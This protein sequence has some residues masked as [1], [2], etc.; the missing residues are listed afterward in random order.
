MSGVELILDAVA[1]GATAGVT[2]ATGAAVRD[3]YTGLREMLRHWLTSRGEQA[4]QTLDAGQAGSVG[5]QLRLSED[6]IRSGADR[7]ERLLAAARELLDRVEA[8]G[9]RTE[10]RRVDLRG[11]QG[12]Q[13][14][15]NNTQHNNFR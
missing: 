15:S 10:V 8:A 1:A 4:L 6:L 3:A 7:D 12:V 14:G 13:L 5:W 11:A 2:D 9:G